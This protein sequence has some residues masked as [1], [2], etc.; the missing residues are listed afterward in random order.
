MTRRRVDPT[1]SAN[2]RAQHGMPHRPQS[3]RC[4]G[5]TCGCHAVTPPRNFRDLVR[6]ARDEAAGADE[7]GQ[8]R[9]ALPGL[10]GTGER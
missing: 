1:V 9:E 10:D 5:C 3:A 4:T 8:G 7:P 2:C 6:M